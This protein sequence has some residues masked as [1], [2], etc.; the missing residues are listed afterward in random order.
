MSWK[1]A[2]RNLAGLW[3]VPGGYFKFLRGYDVV[4]LNSTALCFYGFLVKRLSP[5]TKVICHVREPLLDNW[6]GRTIRAVVRRSADYVIA[7]SQNEMR[8][9]R[10]NDVPGEVVYNYV[11]SAE[12]SPSRGGSLHRKDS[13]VGGEKF[14]VGYFARLDV[15]NGL[16]DFLDVARRNSGD[17]DMAFCIYGHTG[18]ESAEVQMLLA[19]ASAN[20]HVYPMVSNVPP[21]LVD[22]N[23]LLVPFRAPHFSRSVVEAAMLSV[24]SIIYDIESVNETVK[25]G[26]TGYVVPLG[27]VVALSARV[28][29]LKRD[30]GRMASLAHAA[31]SFAM[32]NFSERNYLRIK[33]AINA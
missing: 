25:D 31:H 27:D 16:L 30:P 9:L 28:A 26:E 29:E 32:E 4:Y 14:V 20:V 11:H 6:W 3:M 1:L 5:K 8:N 18:Q 7:I 15:K 13:K 10:L 2:L 21:N 12:Y 24:P 22:I 33:A 23:I 19:N 17:P